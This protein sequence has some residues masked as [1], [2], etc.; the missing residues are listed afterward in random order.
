[1]AKKNPL[2]SFPQNPDELVNAVDFIRYMLDS[3]RGR[4]KGVE[5]SLH[6]GDTKAFALP[7]EVQDLQVRCLVFTTEA[8]A[9]FDAAQG[10]LTNMRDLHTDWVGGAGTDPGHILEKVRDC[11]LRIAESLHKCADLLDMATIHV[12][13]ISR[14]FDELPS[15]VVEHG[16]A[17]LTLPTINGYVLVVRDQATKLEQALAILQGAELSADTHSDGSRSARQY[18]SAIDR[19]RKYMRQMAK[20]VYINA[21]V[22]GIIIQRFEGLTPSLVASLKEFGAAMVRAREGTAKIAKALG[23][24][25]ADLK[26]NDDQVEKMIAQRLVATDVGL[27]CVRPVKMGFDEDGNLGMYFGEDSKTGEENGD[28]S[29]MVAPQHGDG[30]PSPSDT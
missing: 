24:K 7:K 27:V 20:T 28:E 22:S 21:Q 26:P 19:R 13:T 11:G 3:V 10:A 25:W 18:R 9:C 17:P 15:E 8:F 5:T 29:P 2:S 30:S 4:I 1:M 16:V 6:S 14:A 12:G 23:M